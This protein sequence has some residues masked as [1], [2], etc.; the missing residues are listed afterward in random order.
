MQNMVRTNQPSTGI[1]ASVFILYVQ[2]Y[3][4][5]SAKQPVSCPPLQPDHSFLRLC[6]IEAYPNA[7]GLPATLLPFPSFALDGH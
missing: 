3:S 6:P 7:V 5:T 4:N 2:T 1:P